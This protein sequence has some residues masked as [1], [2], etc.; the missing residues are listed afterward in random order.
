MPTDYDHFGEYFPETED[1]PVGKAL[2]ALCIIFSPVLIIL[3]F[4]GLADGFV[5][6]LRKSGWIDSQR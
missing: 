3:A 6:R 2:V 1:I 4:L 5:K